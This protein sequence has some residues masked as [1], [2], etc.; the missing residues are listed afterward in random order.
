VKVLRTK[1]YDVT[2]LTEITTRSIDSEVIA[3]AFQERQIL[4]TEDKD[5]GQLVFASQADSAG[6]ILIR[7]PGNARRS[8]QDAIAALIA[9]HGNN[10]QNAFVVMQPGSVRINRKT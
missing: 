2:A 6:V 4:L 8:L 9:K 5:F 3:Q 10:L 7:Y 1:G